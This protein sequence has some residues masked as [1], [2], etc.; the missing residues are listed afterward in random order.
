ME[1]KKVNVYKYNEL[2]KE[3]QEEILKEYQT[4]CSED[5]ANH[6]LED[7]LNEKAA[8]LLQTN[9]KDIKTELIEVYYDLDYSQGSGA[10]IAFNTTIEEINKKYKKLNNEEVQKIIDV[11]CND[12][13]VQH[14]SGSRYYHE[15]S[16]DVDYQDIT[17]YEDN[18]EEIDKKIDD[19]IELFKSDVY[20]INHDLV[21][22]GYNLLDYD[23]KEE[24][25]LQIN[26]DNHDYFINGEVFEEEDY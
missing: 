23:Y 1:I 8:E 19:M 9:F 24:A 18:L 13:I 7:E 22:Y 6:F 4:R 17:Y 20:S 12:V 25:I 2:S 11:N 3:K 26:E 10:M 5:F 15:N 14:Y 21:K 16:F